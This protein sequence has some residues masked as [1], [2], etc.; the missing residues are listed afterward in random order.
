MTI[1]KQFIAECAGT[2]VLVFI[3]VGAVIANAVSQGGLGI[4]G[5]A[6]AFGFAVIASVYMFAGISGAHINPA[7]TVALIVNRS[8]SFAKGL[9]YI[10]SQLIGA[11]LAALGL[12]I[13]FGSR[14][15]LNPGVTV[16]SSGVSIVQ[17]IIIEAALT[18]FLVLA[19]LFFIK[20]DASQERWLHGA[21]VIGFV[22]AMDI[23]VGGI[24]TGASMNPARTL[25][26]ALLSGV[27]I[28]HWVYWVGPIVG[29]LAAVI[30]NKIW[31][32]V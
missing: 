11:S 29:G 28:N 10:V 15:L 8:I 7:V 17:G 30:I 19:V 5:I 22:V 25:G 24:L 16:L 4:V 3:G 31:D 21:V 18:Y 6:L 23:L 13:A 20:K 2:F 27:W 32:R 9:G 14:S 26:P 12:W 1:L